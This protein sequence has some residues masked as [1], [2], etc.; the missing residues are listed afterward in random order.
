MSRTTTW[1]LAHKYGSW[2]ATILCKTS[3]FGGNTHILRVATF[4]KL[5]ILKHRRFQQFP[6]LMSGL[7]SMKRKIA[8]IF[9]ADIAG[10]SKLTAED[11]E[12][13]A[14]RLASHRALF[15]NLADRFPVRVVNTAGDSIHAEFSRAVDA[16]R[17]AIGVQE[18]LRPRNL[19]YPASQQINC[20]VGFC[21]R[22]TG[23][24]GNGPTSHWTAGSSYHS[25]R[26]YTGANEQHDKAH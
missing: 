8:A 18:R 14:R 3:H 20:R 15:E 11:G 2:Y 19:V 4:G 23:G 21:P 26:R 9:L 25:G 1:Y 13:A 5:N 22:N 10:Y 17:Y 7:T 24:D 12:Q 6:F 16:V